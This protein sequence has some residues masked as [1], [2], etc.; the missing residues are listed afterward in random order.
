MLLLLSC[1][2]N[3]LLNLF[4][5]IVVRVLLCFL[6]FWMYLFFME[7]EDRVALDNCGTNELI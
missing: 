7:R 6:L 3:I 5:Y 2:N 4:V 1:L